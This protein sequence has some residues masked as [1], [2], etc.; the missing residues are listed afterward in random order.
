MSQK[1]I[2]LLRTKRWRH[3]YFGRGNYFMTAMKVDRVNIRVFFLLLVSAFAGQ[4]V[5]AQTPCCD[6]AARLKQMVDTLSAPTMQGRGPGTPGLNTSAEFIRNQFRKVGLKSGV[7]DG[8]FIQEFPY[9][10][11]GSGKKIQ[12]RNVI[13]VSQ[14]TGSAT[15]EVIVVGAHYDHL[16]YGPAFSLAQ[17][18]QKHALHPG[19]DDNA[20]GVAVL[21]EL[22]RYFGTKGSSL[23]KGI[24][25]IAFSGEEEGDLG[26]RYYVAHPV[27]PLADTTTMINLDMVGRVRDNIIGIAGNK[28]GDSLDAILNVAAA[29]SPLM[30]MRGGEEYPDDSDHAPFASAGIPIL[31]VCSGSHD[32]RHKPSDTADK[33]NPKGMA[34]VADL[35]G[36]VIQKLLESPRPRFVARAK[37]N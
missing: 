20:S 2:G 22:A 27:V 23:R 6:E 16:G 15:Q 4:V 29:S 11:A 26:S 36:E 37:Q 25:F 12:L 35:V 3:R 10:S 30:L 13:G 19:A 28:S 5:R 7:E 24:V 8:S 14:G 33:I 1:D 32:D 21:L 17:D 9:I 18:E 34:D 31:Y